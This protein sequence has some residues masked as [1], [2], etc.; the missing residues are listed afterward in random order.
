MKRKAFVAILLLLLLAAAAFIIRMNLPEKRWERHTLKAR[1]YFQQGDLLAADAEYHLAEE[2]KGGYSPIASLEVLRANN[3]L[4]LHDRKI[5]VALGNTRAFIAAHPKN[6][7]ARL[8]LAEIEFGLARWTEALESLDTVLI[9][10]ASN[11]KARSLLANLRLRQ[12]RLDLAE[13]QLRILAENRPD[14]LPSLF[15]LLQGLQSQGRIAPCRPYLQRLVRDFPSI[16]P[17]RLLLADGWMMEGKTDSA[18]VLLK[19]WVPKDADQ[20]RDI[21]IREARI[22]E[23]GGDPDRAL[24]LLL[25]FKPKDPEN[26]DLAAER[27]YLFAK[28]SEL[29]SALV[30]YDAL[31]ESNPNR[32]ALYQLLAHYLELASLRPGK[33]LERLKKVQFSQPQNA[34]LLRQEI[35]TYLAIGQNHKADA[36]VASAADS[37]RTQFEAFRRE[38]PEDASFIGTLAMVSYFEHLGKKPEMLRTAAA[39]HRQWPKS[40]TAAFTYARLLAQLGAYRQAFQVMGKIQEPSAGLRLFRAQM[41]LSGGLGREGW[42][43]IKP[44]VQG[45]EAPDGAYLL[46]ASLVGMEG[47]DQEMAAYLEKAIAADSGDAIALN[48]LAWEYGAV[49]RDSAKAFPLLRRLK[50]LKEQDPRYMDTMGW[51]YVLHG[52]PAKG[53]TFL[54][55]ALLWVP[56]HPGFLYHL[57]VAHINLHRVALGKAEIQNALNSSRPFAEKEEARQFLASLQQ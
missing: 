18:E 2:A 5:D 22:A 31:T 51:I 34:V 39:L 33:A 10:D 43:V 8:F 42:Q 19:E 53:E 15:P 29:D 30:I 52:Q 57:G 21:T 46:A 13:E 44:L 16:W 25:R 56:D 12:G 54:Q 6:T 14:S 26:R 40:P 36:L 47:K 35:A 24:G 20:F 45:D 49:R 27:A 7:D 38:T 17:A 32:F 4:N 28:R 41:A 9:L 50:G 1:L 48:N 37:L 3:A 55:Q 11:F 23:I